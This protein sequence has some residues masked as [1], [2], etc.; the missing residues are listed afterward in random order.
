VNLRLVACGL[1]PDRL[2]FRAVR[3][4]A[5]NGAS[6]PPRFV[7]FARGHVAGDTPVNTP[8]VSREAVEAG[9]RGP[10]II[11][12]YDSTIILPPGAAAAADACGNI[13]VTL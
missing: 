13:V 4:A 1:R 10:A 6:P 8:V 11:E 5:R 9:L 7:S 12:S 3:V 2:D